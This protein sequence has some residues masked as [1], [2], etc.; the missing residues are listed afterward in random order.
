MR[1]LCHYQQVIQ[2]N[3]DLRDITGYELQHLLALLAA[4]GVNNYA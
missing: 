3:E 4:E 2:G 1:G